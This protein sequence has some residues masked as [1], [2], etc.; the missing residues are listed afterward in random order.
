MNISGKKETTPRKN[1]YYCRICAVILVF[2]MFFTST[3]EAAD[4]TSKGNTGTGIHQENTSFIPSTIESMVRGDGKYLD[5]QMELER[6]NTYDSVKNGRLAGVE[7]NGSG[8]KS[9]SGAEVSLP[10]TEYVYSGYAI[11]PVPTVS[12]DGIELTENDDYELFYDNNINVGTGT[13]IIRGKGNYGGETKAIFTILPCDITTKNDGNY[14]TKITFNRVSYTYSGYPCEPEAKVIHGGITLKKNVDYKVEYID[15]VNANATGSDP[16]VKIIGEGNYTG[17]RSFKFSINPTSLAYAAITFDK[18]DSVRYTGKEITNSIVN[19]RLDDKTLYEGTDYEVPDKGQLVGLY[20]GCYYV[21]IEGKGNYKGTLNGE[22]IITDVGNEQ[23]GKTGDLYWEVSGNDSNGYDLTISGN[24]EMPN[25]TDAR[26]DYDRRTVPWIKYTDKIKTIY[27]SNGCRNI[28]DYAFYNCN[29]TR[30]ISIPD[31]VKRIGRYSFYNCRSISGR[32]VLPSTLISISQNAFY[33]CNGFTGE[34]KIPSTVEDIGSS[35]FSGCSGFSGKLILPD[36]LRYIGDNAFAKCRGFS[37]ELIIPSKVKT[38]Q[39]GIFRECTGFSGRLSLPE[40]LIE[41]GSSAFQGCYGFTGSLSIPSSVEKIGGGAFSDCK[42]FSGSLLLPENLKKLDESAFC[43]CNGF[44]GDLRIPDGLNTIYSETFM[45]CSGFSGKLVIPAGIK[46]I[47]GEAFYGAKFSEI[48][49]GEGLEKIGDFAFRNNSYEDETIALP[50]SL[51]SIGEEAFSG[52]K[53][54]RV[55][56]GKNLRS[57]GTDTFASSKLI[58]YEADEGN[59]FFSSEDGVLYNKDKSVLISYPRGKEDRVFYI[60]DSV[61]SF[62]SYAFSNCENLYSLYVH[63]GVNFPYERIIYNCSRLGYVFMADTVAPREAHASALYSNYRKYENGHEFK[64]RIY[65]PS[66]AMGYDIKP[67]S[68]FEVIK[69]E[70]IRPTGIKLAETD[71]LIDRSS[72]GSTYISYSVL[73]TNASSRGIIAKSSN[74]DVVYAEISTLNGKPVIFL[75]SGKTG[76]AV[77]TLTTDDGLVGEIIDVTVINGGSSEEDDPAVENTYTVLFK[78]R[79]RVYEKQTISSGQVAVRPAVDPGSEGAVFIGW[80]NGN[81]LWN[82]TT[83]VTYDLVLTAKYAETAIEENGSTGSGM[84]PVAEVGEDKKLYLVTG[85]KYTIGES[86]YRSSN[87]KAATVDQTKGIITAKAAGNGNAIISKGSVSYNVIVQKP[88]FNKVFKST[89]LLV[90]N[91]EIIRLSGI[92][93]EYAVHYPITW[94]SSNEKIASV[95]NGM[96]TALAKGRA[97]IY[98][99]VG[100]RKYKAVVN[101]RDTY[102]VP[103]KL[104]SIATININPL[105]TVSLKYNKSV[106]I[107]KGA[108]WTGVSSNELVEIKNDSG[109]V[110]GYKNNVVEIYTSGKVK[111]V[112]AGSTIVTGTDVNSNVVTLKINVIP[113]STKNVIYLNIGKRE[114]LSFPKVKNSEARWLLDDKTLTSN[115]IVRIN[116]KGTIEGIKVGSTKVTC[117]YKGFTFNATIYVENPSLITDSKLKSEGNGYK[118]DLKRH[119]VYVIKATEVYQTP[120]WSSKKREVAFVDENG[121]IYA[122]QPGKTIISTKIN[123]KTIKIS[124]TVSESAVAPVSESQADLGISGID[125]SSDVSKQYNI[126]EGL[127]IAQIEAGS[128]AEKAGLI[129]GDVIV[130]MAGESVDSMEKTKEILKHYKPGDVIEIVVKKGADDYKEETVSVT[131]QKKSEG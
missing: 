53:Y 26:G 22:W 67:W 85:Q 93:S 57:I 55:E 72:Q 52:G 87:T 49:I 51:K 99:Y 129:L 97:N 28:G 40:G 111:A 105:N 37:G 62:S 30:E 60:P 80:I 3:V 38:I 116:D 14:E 13:I 71:V 81:S 131:L 34:L 61:N 65:V 36:S 29:Q 90:G 101:I 107:P 89:T 127:Y 50:N 106:F 114:K 21:Q 100:G 18:G 122:R 78:D 11:T 130:K 115:G 47:G 68:D 41:I 123:G 44:T 98:A 54:R 126:P 92:E 31:S 74:E 94:Q 118:L 84:D 43:D 82:F 63:S 2:A 66:N 5:V 59:D 124:I 16:T 46:G 110:S 27:I 88:E 113:V 77:I 32:L 12:V 23:S 48:E 8:I 19:L 125:I 45:G 17:F 103:S 10:E 128:A 91:S 15:N 119:D 9:I 42:G 96:V 109:K 75:S 120:V 121:T 24:G 1:W 102:T 76:T 86:G 56:I 6:S 104:S 83:P 20:I 35:A 64:T 112:G 7:N 4:L 95:N 73:P 25:Y 39:S 79:G 70:Y 58:E 33:N 108:K 117:L 69:G